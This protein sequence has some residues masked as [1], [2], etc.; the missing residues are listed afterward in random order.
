MKR[1]L[2]GLLLLAVI[3]SISAQSQD[4]TAVTEDWAPYNYIENGEIKGMS[5]EIVRATLAEAGFKPEIHVYA[6]A[7]AYKMAVEYENVLIFTILRNK[8]RENLFKWIGPVLPLEKMCLFKLAERTDIRV[9]SLEDAKKYRTGVARN[10]STHQFL[11]E[12]GFTEQENLFPVPKQEQNI[13]KLFKGRIDLVTDREITLAQKMKKMAMSIRTLDK[14][15][16][17]DHWDQGFYMAFGRKTPDSV[18]E[19]VR[20]AFKKITA[21]GVPDTIRKKYMNMY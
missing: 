13:A 2:T 9:D 4:I 21:D 17:L 5:T 15:F 19:K 20:S 7:R 3:P 14:V 16:V 10:S 8:E 12:N 18:V 6:W 11:I 1:I